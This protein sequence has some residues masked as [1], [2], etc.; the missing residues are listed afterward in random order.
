MH[1]KFQNQYPVNQLKMG[2]LSKGLAGQGRL[3]CNTS[4]KGKSFCGP[5]QVQ[6]RP[7]EADIVGVV[8]LF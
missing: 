2:V 8:L 6:R 1:P 5:R 3:F 4:R 7:L